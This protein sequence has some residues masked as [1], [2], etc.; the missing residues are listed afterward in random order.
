M[1]ST[2]AMFVKFS[3]LQQITA[4]FIRLLGRIGGKIFEHARAGVQSAP[5]STATP[6]QP[7][8]RVHRAKPTKSDQAVH[9]R[10]GEIDRR[11]TCSTSNMITILESKQ[12]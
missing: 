11:V 10:G 8:E 7:N 1:P 4:T 2:S 9:T 6:R 3:L 12:P 5:P